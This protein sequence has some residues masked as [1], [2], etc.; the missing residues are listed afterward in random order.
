VQLLQEP[1]LVAR[2]KPVEA[3]IVAQHA[4]LVL[5]WHAAMLIEPVAKMSRRRG[6]R[7]IVSGIGAARITVARP[8]LACVRCAAVDR[9]AVRSSR[10]ISRTLRPIALRPGLILGARPALSLWL[11]LWRLC[12][13]RIMRRRCWA[14]RSAGPLLPMRPPGRRSAGHRERRNQS[15]APHA[16]RVVSPGHHLS[17]FLFR[18]FFP[19]SQQSP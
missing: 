8:S 5:H 2:R 14:G 11:V 6:A 18:F 10:R 12:R 1:L 9:A 16:S 13:S 7:I 4:L 15:C 19:L 17:Q 3:G